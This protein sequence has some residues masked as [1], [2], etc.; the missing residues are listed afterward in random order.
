[1]IKPEEIDFIEEIGDINGQ[2]VKLIRVVGGFFAA[3]GKAPN[4]NRDSVLAAGSH[5]AIVKFELQKKYGKNF[6]EHLQKSESKIEPVVFEKTNY[7]K[8][9]LVKKGYSLYSVVTGSDV[10]V[11][12][13]QYGNEVLKQDGLIKSESIEM[14]PQISF[15]DL[16]K[17]REAIDSEVSKSLIMA[18]ADT[19]I[20]LNKKNIE[21]P[22]AP[23]KME[24]K[25][26]LNG[27]K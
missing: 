21:Y 12:L 3:S 22:T 4:E 17:S 24:A 1:M 13:S 23:S 10:S 9:D 15:S 14:V 8:N 2:P 20:S 7:L 5:S 11:I 18:M 6:R 16:K 19:A 27:K 26:V 25:K